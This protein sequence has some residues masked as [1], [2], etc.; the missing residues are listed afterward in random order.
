MERSADLVCFSLL[1]VQIVEW[2]VCALN[3]QNAISFAVLCCVLG[4]EDEQPTDGEL[5]LLHR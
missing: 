2:G 3:P 4:E 1:L 5:G